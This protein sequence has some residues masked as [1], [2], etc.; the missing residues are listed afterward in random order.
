MPVS[1]E[2]ASDFAKRLTKTIIFWCFDLKSHLTAIVADCGD[3]E[4]K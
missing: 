1:A 4:K 2:E 3:S